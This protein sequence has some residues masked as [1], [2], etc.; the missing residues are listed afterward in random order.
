MYYKEF[1]IRWNDIDANRHLANSAYLNFMSHTRMGYMIENG[2]GHKEMVQYNIGPVVFEEQVF[3]FKEIF[4]GK[5]IRVSFELGGASKD[6]MFFKF[7]HNFYDHKGKN[8]ARG[9]MKGA[10]IDLKT[11]KTCAL[12]NPLMPM[13]DAAHKTSDFTILTKE[14]MRVHG[15]VPID[16][17]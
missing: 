17:S 16:L 2:V 5:P 12:P 4:Q 7:I 11:R 6:G 10:W 3:F 15:Q 9:I 13:L 14:D 8:L 1:D